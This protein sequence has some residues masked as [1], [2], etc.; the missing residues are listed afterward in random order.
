MDV[1]ATVDD[2]QMVASVEIINLRKRALHPG[3]LLKFGTLDL[4][5]TVGVRLLPAFFFVYQV[6]VS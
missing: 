3:L 2:S 5:A 1:S 4:M 6:R